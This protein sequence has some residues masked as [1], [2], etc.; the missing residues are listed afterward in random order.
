MPDSI[1]K[2]LLK[3]GDSPSVPGTDIWFTLVNPS[4]D[5]SC[6]INIGCESSEFWN[7]IPIAGIVVPVKVI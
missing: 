4:L 6:Q 5:S 3:Q 2:T 7:N 1:A